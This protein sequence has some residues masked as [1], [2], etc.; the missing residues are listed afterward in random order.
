MKGDPYGNTY[1]PDACNDSRSQHPIDEL[2]GNDP[3]RWDSA[4][5]NDPR[6]N[7]LFDQP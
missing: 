3:N 2:F 5:M 6:L 7:Q 4:H 1:N